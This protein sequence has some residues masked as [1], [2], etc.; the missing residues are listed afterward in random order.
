MKQSN[1]QT[2]VTRP[3]GQ[4]PE[5]R[6]V[7]P[8]DDTPDSKRIRK[9]A[10]ESGIKPTMP[11]LASMNKKDM[12]AIIQSIWELCDEVGVNRRNESAPKHK[13]TLYGRV[14]SGFRSNPD[15][16]LPSK[17]NLTF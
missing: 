14:L 4:I 15:P 2:T 7:L 8:T 17:T 11:R 6:L 1:N 9:D 16:E 3:S 5:Q 10:V 13:L 12:A